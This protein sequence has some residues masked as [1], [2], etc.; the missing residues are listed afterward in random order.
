MDETVSESIQPRPRLDTPDGN[1]EVA[2]VSSSK[3]KV[4]PKLTTYESFNDEGNQMFDITDFKLL[5]DLL[6]E[7]AVCAK[8][9]NSLTVLTTN[10]IGLS[11]KLTIKCTGCGSEVS[12]QNDRK[13]H[14]EQSEINTRL[15]YGFRCIGKGEEAAKTVCAI[16]NLPQPPAFKYYNKRICKAVKEV[17]VESFKEAV[18]ESVVAN[19]FDRDS[20]CVSLDGTWQRRGHRSLN[21]AVTAVSV[22][23]GKVLDVKVYSKHC[24]CKKRLEREHEDNC[25]ANFEG[26]SG[27]MEVKGV[28]E[29]FTESR[30]KYGVK[31]KYY[32]GDGDSSAFPTVQ[33]LMPYGPD[34][35]KEKLE[36]V[37]HVQKRMGSRLKTLKKHLSGQKLKDEKTIGGRGR[38]TDSAIMDIQN[39]YGL[40]IRRNT[41][42]LD[43]MK[44]A[45]WAVYFHIL[46]SDEKP[47]HSFVLRVR[48]AGASTR[49]RRRTKR[50]IPTKITSTS[51]R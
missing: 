47:L 50:H 30:D 7:I 44:K 24:R 39:Y 10:R 2:K 20:L 3:K 40:A 43:D 33:K 8:C 42:S 21:G 27:S 13:K 51:L 14:N 12:G 28:S 48:R 23:T 18:E 41:T 25:V 35:Q 16:M 4:G 36:C 34:F 32:L 19:N 6:R 46:S 45:V 15:V 31:Y 9:G 29:M 38:L 22:D 37:G 1:D 17:C 49:K 5:D 11:V 26:P